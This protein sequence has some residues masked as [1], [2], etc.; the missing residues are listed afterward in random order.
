MLIRIFGETNPYQQIDSNNIF[1]N[2]ANFYANNYQNGNLTA[3][4]SMW[5]AQGINQ[6]SDLSLAQQFIFS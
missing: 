5:Y 4:K 6:V 1:L 3:N 2:N